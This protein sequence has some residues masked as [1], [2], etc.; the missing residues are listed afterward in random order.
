M[1]TR[2][3]R[4]ARLPPVL[5]VQFGRF[6]WKET[7]GSQD[8]SGVKC[9]IMK[10]VAFQ[11][12]L[13]VYEFCTDDVQKKLKASRDKFM[14]EEEE[15]I[16]LKLKGSS[17]SNSEDALMDDVVHDDELK[18]ALA[19]SLKADTEFMETENSV[20]PGLP[21]DFQG[22]YELFAVVTHKG[23][24]ADG[25]H[26]MGWVK[27]EHHKNAANVDEEH[28]DWFVFKFNALAIRASPLTS[29]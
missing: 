13:D 23:R 3:Q 28:D 14:A 10:P 15:R 26:Y 27:A 7:P 21:T 18:A 20:G 2:K 6:Y 5:V 9:K 25:G 17:K 8:H 29:N 11:S 12:I 19:L 24:D 1:W 22:K 16:A 4:F